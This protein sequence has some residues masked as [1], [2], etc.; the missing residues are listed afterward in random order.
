MKVVITFTFCCDNLWKSKFMAL[1]KP[2]KLSEFF[3]PTLWPP[4]F[5]V[6]TLTLTLVWPTHPSDCIGPDSD[7][8]LVCIV[9]LGARLSRCV[10]VRRISLDG[11]GNVLYPVLSS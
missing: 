8:I 11:E 9:S 5:G 7:A 4:S 1:E 3:S 10:C 2:G 6:L